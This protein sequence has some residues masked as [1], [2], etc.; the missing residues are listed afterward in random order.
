MS[1]MILALLTVLILLMCSG[2]AQAENLAAGKPYW[3]YP[4]S[5]LPHCRDE[6]TNPVR[7]TDGIFRTDDRFYATALG[8]TTVTWDGWTPYRTTA[9]IVLDLD[10]VFRITNVRLHARAGWGT[11]ANDV[12]YPFRVSF[13]V[14]AKDLQFYHVGDAIDRASKTSPYGL[15]QHWMQTGPISIDGRYICVVL[16]TEL[17]A[18][19]SLDELEIIGEPAAGEPG[20]DFK[21]IDIQA[22][23]LRDVNLLSETN[24]M[25]PVQFG[26]MPLHVG[27]NVRRAQMAVRQADEYVN[28]EELPAGERAASLQ[29]LADLKAR[30]AELQLETASPSSDQRL[31][32]IGAETRDVFD[33]AQHISHRRR[34]LFVWARDIWK[35]L[36]PLAQPHSDTPYLQQIQVVMLGNEYE[37]AGCAITNFRRETVRLRALLSS[38]DTGPESDDS[39]SSPAALPFPLDRVVLRKMVYSNCAANTLVGDALVELDS[40][41]TITLPPGETVQ[42]WATL[43]ARDV[44]PGDYA[45]KLRIIP[46]QA[47]MSEQGVPLRVHVSKVA[48][49][50][51]QPVHFLCFAYPHWYQ[52]RPD[53]RKGIEDLMAHYCDVFCLPAGH[54]PGMNDQGDITDPSCAGLDDALDLHRGAK[55]L[56]VCGFPGSFAGGKITFDAKAGLDPTYEKAFANW[57]NWLIGKIKERGYDYNHIVYCPIDEPGHAGEGAEIIGVIGPLVKKVDPNLMVSENPNS[58]FIARYPVAWD[59]F[60]DIWMPNGNHVY[61]DTPLAADGRKWLEQRRG[62]KWTYLCDNS[63]PLLGAL[64]Y[65]RNHFWKA[66][67]LG[68]KGVSWWS[69]GDEYRGDNPASWQYPWGFGVVYRGEKGPIPTRRWE[70]WREGVEDYWLLALV[71]ETA[72]AAEQSGQTAIADAAKRLVADAISG[73]NADPD[74]VTTLQKYRVLLIQTAEELK[75]TIEQ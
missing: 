3:L 38:L 7:M 12:F 64:G 40:G 67:A 41:N 27:L 17:S 50:G 61:P 39:G 57:L 55:S 19:I 32:L 71:R 43:H 74:N 14:A 21:P 5:F 23:F 15:A 66:Y 45:L 13:Y 8:A 75:R 1:K 56:F 26:P 2:A 34:P 58:P 47:D 63:R 30:L 33:A 25:N 9:C 70:A 72:E 60:I 48:L 24:G 73:V 65:Y 35:P 37:S 46:L 31:G 11:G 54:Y 42:L 69:Y 68:Y 16:Q 36:L 4:P 22:V 20:H 53:P 6:L 59:S 52:M 28:S 18:R 10:E 62:E 29:H 44:E 49:G 51:V